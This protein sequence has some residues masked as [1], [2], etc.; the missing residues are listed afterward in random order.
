VGGA[1]PAERF[2]VSEA[3]LQASPGV[4]FLPSIKSDKNQNFSQHAVFMY[5]VQLL[6]HCFHF[7]LFNLSISI[8]HNNKQETQLSLT[9]RSTHLRKRN[10]VALLN[11]MC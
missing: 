2:F 5:T 6:L 11:G 3:S 9:N 7:S 1:Q 8:S 4:G 10:G